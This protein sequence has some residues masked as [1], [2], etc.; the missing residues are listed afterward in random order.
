ME[1]GI[2]VG[3]VGI[4]YKCLLSFYKFIIKNNNILEY[5]IILLYKINFFQNTKKL[6]WDFKYGLPLF[7][8]TE[9]TLVNLSPHPTY[10]IQP[11]ICLP[12]MHQCAS[13]YIMSTKSCCS[14]AIIKALEFFFSFI[15]LFLEYLNQRCKEP[16]FGLEFH[17]SK[18]KFMFHYDLVCCCVQHAYI[19]TLLM[20]I[21]HVMTCPH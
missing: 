21:K 13:L 4:K 8:N 15:L 18:K 1:N 14:F 12:H 17:S 19:M 2:L 16:I 11:L 20:N 3:F 7:N 9:L 10:Q 6:P 5:K